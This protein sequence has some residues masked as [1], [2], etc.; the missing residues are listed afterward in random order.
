MEDL[1]VIQ[2][3]KFCSNHKKA[4]LNDKKCGCFF[5]LEIFDPKEITDWVDDT[6]RTAICPYCDVDSVIG[7]S[8][9]YPITKEFQTKMKKYWFIDNSFPGRFSDLRN[10]SSDCL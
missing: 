4:L 9:G 3:H 1:S 8:S 7:E 6:E 5:C 10:N 2:A